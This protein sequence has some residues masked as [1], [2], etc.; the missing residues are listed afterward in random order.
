VWSVF[1]LC[2]VI[3]LVGYGVVGLFAR[4]VTPWIAGRAT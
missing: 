3:A 4:L 1:L 2:A